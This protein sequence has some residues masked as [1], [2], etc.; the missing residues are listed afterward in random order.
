ME[1][2]DVYVGNKKSGYCSFSCAVFGSAPA[3]SSRKAK[4]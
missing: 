4:V 3:L 2:E 1:G